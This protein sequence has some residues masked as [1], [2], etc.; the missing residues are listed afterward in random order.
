M[1]YRALK[2]LTLRPWFCLPYIKAI[3]W[4]SIKIDTYELT[5]LL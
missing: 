4:S 5:D 1:Y 2:G 3:L